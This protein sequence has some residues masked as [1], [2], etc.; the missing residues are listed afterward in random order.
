MRNPIF[1]LALTSSMAFSGIGMAED[2]KKDSTPLDEA[3]R[4]TAQDR[5]NLPTPGE[6]LRAADGKI[7]MKKLTAA[8]GEVSPVP[9]KSSDAAQAHQ[10]GICLADGFISLY[11]KDAVRVKAN[12][13]ILLEIATQLGADEAIIAEGKN[14]GTLVDAGNW[15]EASTAAD[16]F[17]TRLLKDLVRDGDVEIVTVASASGWLRGFGLAANE[18]AQSYNGTT[19]RLFR[20]PELAAHLAQ[21]VLKLSPGTVEDSGKAAAALLE[22]S[23]LTSVAQDADIA[24]ESVEKIALAAK[25]G[26]TAL[27]GKPVTK[28]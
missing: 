28:P 4:Q 21:M 7:D 23:K 17:R 18:I 25:E 15:S 5:F 14:I 6:M 27:A 9:P 2:V 13:K 1:Y 20:Q 3:S 16:S 19:S 22:I 26:L 10:L 8:L 24:K 12:G 11:A